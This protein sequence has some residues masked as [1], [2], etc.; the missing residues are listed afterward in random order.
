[1]T[2]QVLQ[3]TPS[4][5]AART[6]IGSALFLTLLVVAGL[7]ALAFWPRGGFAPPR[8]PPI[9]APIVFDEFVNAPPP[10]PTVER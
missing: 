7:S 3:S 8:R 4:N 5:A 10:T 6:S 9:S 2:E 1:V